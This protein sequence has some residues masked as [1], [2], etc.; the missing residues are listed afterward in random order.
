MTQTEAMTMNEA[1]QAVLIQAGFKVEGT[2]VRD[3]N[4]RKV[5]RSEIE[6]AL[7]AAGIPEVTITRTSRGMVVTA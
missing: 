5:T 6:T 3:W 2:L 1:I 7:D 4:T